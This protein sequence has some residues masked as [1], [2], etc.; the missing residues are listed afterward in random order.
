MNRG[1]SESPFGAPTDA[2]GSPGVVPVWRYVFPHRMTTS[3]PETQDE[4]TIPVPG[5]ES[6]PSPSVP[7]GARSR[8]A[9]PESG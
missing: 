7:P 3:T 5:S 8:P 1:S 4:P 2:D 6:T 9:R